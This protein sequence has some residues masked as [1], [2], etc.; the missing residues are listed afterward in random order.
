MTRRNIIQFNKLRTTN[1]LKV[2]K[3]N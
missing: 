2:M 3:D 1:S